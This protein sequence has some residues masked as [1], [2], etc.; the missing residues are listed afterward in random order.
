MI[1]ESFNSRTLV[2]MKVALD[3]ACKTL[4]AGAGNTGLGATSPAKSS[5]A[6]S[7]ATKRWVA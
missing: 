5:N 1:A 4:P 2:N 6:W 7:A 3:R